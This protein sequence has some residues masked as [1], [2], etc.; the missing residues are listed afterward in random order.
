MKLAG[1]DKKAGYDW[2]KRKL[3]GGTK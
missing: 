2:Q 1:F 3:R